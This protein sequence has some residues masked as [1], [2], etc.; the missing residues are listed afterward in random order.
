MC[1]VA[2]QPPTGT[3]GSLYV[4]KSLGE[5]G[6]GGAII[7]MQPLW[8]ALGPLF[9]VPVTAMALGPAALC[10]RSGA[11]VPAGAWAMLLAGLV[12][13]TLHSRC[14]WIAGLFCGLCLA[15][16]V[17]AAPRGARSPARG[18][19]LRRQAPRSA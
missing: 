12:A 13:G 10:L 6:Y 17:A 7:E 11:K 16:G 5:A 1:G 9:A 19:P 8:V 4:L 3:D 2:S 18:G 14:M 15:Y